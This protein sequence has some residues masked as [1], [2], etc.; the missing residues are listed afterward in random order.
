ML[1]IERFLPPF[2]SYRIVENCIVPGKRFFLELMHP[3]KNR[4]RRAFL[5]I[6]HFVFKRSPAEE[7]A[8]VTAQGRGHLDAAVAVNA[9]ELVLVAHIAPYKRPLAPH[10]GLESST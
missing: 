10:A 5:H 3:G 2:M 1:W 7:A 8:L 4:L 9:V 6:R